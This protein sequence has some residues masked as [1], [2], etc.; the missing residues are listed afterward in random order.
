MH[1]LAIETSCDE[2]AVAILEC[3][4]TVEHAEFAVL[5]N[6]LY[7]QAAQHAEYGGVYPAL[8]KREHQKNLVPL[9]I[10]ALTEANLLQK[11]EPTMI[12]HSGLERIVDEEFRKDT[13]DFLK[14]HAMP[15]IDLI[16]VTSGPGLEP[17]LWTGISFAQTLS[18][19]WN[20]PVLGINHMEGHIVSA[21]LKSADTA[22]TRRPDAEER[23]KNKQE[24][25][26]YT[27]DAIRFPV[28]ALLISGGHTELVLSKNWFEYQLI[29]K[30][31]DDA[32]GEA[33][34]K[35][36]RIL[37]MPYPG[38]PEISRAAARARE[39]GRRS[40]ISLPRPMLR[41]EN[42]DFSFSGLK[43]A[44]MYLVRDIGGLSDEV[45]E[46][47]AREFEDAVTDVVVGKTQRALQKT[48][49]RTLMVGG[50]VSANRSIR[51]GLLNLA[52]EECAGLPVLFPDASLTGDNAVM[53][54][55]A[56]YVRKAAGKIVKTEMK[57]V[58]KLRLDTSS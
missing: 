39:S 36:A 16:A 38:G 14:T 12:N 53:I 44:V 40:D 19:A 3:A 37:G 41:E 4:G 31:R 45:R 43:T 18:E 21:L 55:A 50:G 58:G 2:T 30:T 52:R 34:D 26:Y 29:G 24:P 13:L 11:S 8:A 1:I 54:G 32:A 46:D 33:F 35:V 7:S 51:E 42:C 57:A 6:A 49:A 17:A 20:I 23:G 56:A 5:G 28:L 10:R 27:L 22:E 47:I 25:K 48:G 9:T 15:D